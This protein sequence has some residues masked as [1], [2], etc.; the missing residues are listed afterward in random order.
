MLKFALMPSQVWSER[1]LDGYDGFGGYCRCEKGCVG[2]AQMHD[3][4]GNVG[5]D[6]VHLIFVTG[7]IL[8]GCQRPCLGRRAGETS[9]DLDVQ[10]AAWPETFCDEN[11]RLDI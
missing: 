6:D 3:V 4:G 8:V 9:E 7:V 1:I 10:N 11:T 2:A 5:K